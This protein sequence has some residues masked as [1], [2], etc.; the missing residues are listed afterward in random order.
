MKSLLTQA[1]FTATVYMR[2]ELGASSVLLCSRKQ[3]AVFSL[4]WHCCAVNT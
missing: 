1:Q 3:A 2:H 4:L